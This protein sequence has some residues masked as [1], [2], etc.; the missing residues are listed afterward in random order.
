VLLSALWEG[1]G[2]MASGR[3]TKGLVLFVAGTV[4]SVLGGV[5]GTMLKLLTFGRRP[6]KALPDRLNPLA[7]VWLAI[8]L[9]SLYDAYN[10]A[11]GAT[12]DDADL[13]D[14]EEYEPQ[15]SEFVYG[16]AN[17]ANAATSAVTA[18][19]GPETAMA[20]AGGNAATGNA[21]TGGNA[22]TGGATGADLAN[23]GNNLAALGQDADQLRRGND[24]AIGGSGAE[25]DG[26][27]NGGQG[28]PA[29]AP[30]RSPAGGGFDFSG[31][32][33]DWEAGVTKAQ[34][35]DALG[36]D[37][38]VL[39]VFGQYLPS[40][41]VFHSAD[42]ALT[43]IPVQAWQSAQGREWTGGDLPTSDQ[44]TGY[45]DSAAGRMPP[46]DQSAGTVH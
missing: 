38:Q 45:P 20:Q 21:A 41:K 29:P 40:D 7:L 9:Y 30:A 2:Q 43:L 19:A 8:Y 34:L 13:L 35:M 3:T 27:A 26:G 42:E 18:P 25:G 10:I 11:S 44:P 23:T 32:G 16:G 46:G 5:K 14:Y 31:A 28:A 15:E 1:T 4:F 12:E 39:G 24:A 17:G 6:I 33:L 22:E 36:D 37:E